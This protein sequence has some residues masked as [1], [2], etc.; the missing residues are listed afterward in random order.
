MKRS[1]FFFYL[2]K[3]IRKEFP[4][5]SVENVT[6]DELT[7]FHSFMTKIVNCHSEI[8][9]TLPNVVKTISVNGN[10]GSGKSYFVKNLQEHLTGKNYNIALSR[11]GV[12]LPE[13]D[14]LLKKFYT[15]EGEEKN[16]A[17][18]DLQFFVLF[19]FEFS[20]IINY[21][22][23]VEKHYLTFAKKKQNL[24]IRDV[25]FI[26]EGVFR[27]VNFGANSYEFSL[28]EAAAASI[29]RTLKFF[30]LYEDD[31]Y[32]YMTTDPETCLKNIKKRSRQNGE[33]TGID[34]DYLKSLDKNFKEIF[35]PST[36]SFTNYNRS[37]I[38][39]DFMKSPMYEKNK[40][41]RIVD[42]LFGYEPLF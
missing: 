17:C 36:N 24:L 8:G 42:A 38:L 41:S 40:Q 32:F 31:L 2:V 10:I 33:T 20:F 19:F 25:S 30:H 3:N 12:H 34:I 9:V 15:S 21:I 35:V 29:K 14:K 27:K 13:F 18:V 26:A 37:V 4:S 23:L 1:D 11:E 16:R 39:V 6:Y 5:A 22:T 28:I 7:K